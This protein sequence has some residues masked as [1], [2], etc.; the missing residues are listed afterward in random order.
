MDLQVLVP[1]LSDHDTQAE[2]SPELLAEASVLSWVLELTWSPQA[3][4]VGS[5]GHG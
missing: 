4:E 1:M 3:E 2:I 5:E